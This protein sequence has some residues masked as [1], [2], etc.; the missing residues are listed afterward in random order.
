MLPEFNDPDVN[1]AYCNSNVVDE[2]G[3]V[4]KNFYNAH[5]YYNSLPNPQKWNRNYK[6]GGDDEI[7]SGVGIIN[8][9]PNAS[10]VL[11]RKNALMNIDKKV[12]LSLLTGGD[13]YIY[14]NLLKSGKIAY[15]SKP[16]N[17]HRRHNKSF[18]SR[19]SL[20]PD[21]TLT[22]YYRIHSYV[23]DNFNVTE[24]TFNKM[25]EY[26]K[27]NLRKLWPELSDNEF[28][29]LYNEYKL[30]KIFNKILQ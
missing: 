9:I 3:H 17:Y 18:V 15:N 23:L 1:I 30:T 8:T 2:K 11:M 24:K 29:S 25:T 16:L 26:V 14:L 21:E 4:T 7:I 27:S 10:A 22:D 28:E 20:N 19:T 5:G 12:L 13:W 6:S